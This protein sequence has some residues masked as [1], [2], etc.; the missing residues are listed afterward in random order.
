M[1][2]DRVQLRSKYNGKPE[3][4]YDQIWRIAWPMEI[5]R[6]WKSESIANM[7]LNHEL[8]KLLPY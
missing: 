3:I 1:A 6:S 8:P 4:S 5:R 7:T 2:N